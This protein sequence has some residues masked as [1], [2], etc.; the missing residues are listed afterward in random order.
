MVA[1]LSYE[2]AVRMA[3][4]EAAIVM[5]HDLSAFLDVAWRFPK[6]SMENICLIL[7]QNPNAVEINTESEW[8]QCCY[9]LKSDAGAI[10]LMVEKHNVVYL[11]D[12]SQ[13]DGKRTEPVPNPGQAYDALIKTL[14]KEPI[15]LEQ[16][17]NRIAYYDASE[18][19]WCVS[20][21]ANTDARFYSIITYPDHTGA[22]RKKSNRIDVC[23]GYGGI[24]AL[25]KIWY[26]YPVYPHDQFTGG[27]VSYDGRYPAEKYHLCGNGLSGSRSVQR[28]MGILQRPYD[29][30]KAGKRQRSGYPCQSTGSKEKRRRGKNPGACGTACAADYS[31]NAAPSGEK[32]LV[33]TLETR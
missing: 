19:T 9:Q 18:H 22:G 32:G 33:W 16:T 13:T 30:T 11:Y 23:R 7:L 29:G 5:Q 15:T 20:A 12:I 14:G 24:Y 2:E 28:P 21:K 3:Q 27:A 1:I 26:Q 4:L 8:R 6:L 31:R 25:S 10:T 17:K